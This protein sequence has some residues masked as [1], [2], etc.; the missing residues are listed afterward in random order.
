MKL[1]FNIYM[2]INIIMNIKTIIT[3]SLLFYFSNI[4]A[5][6]DL[7]TWTLIKKA[8]QTEIYADFKGLKKSGNMSTIWLLENYSQAKTDRFKRWY[9]TKA[10]YEVDC[11]GKMSKLI[12]VILHNGNMGN[13]TI[14]RARLATSDWLNM[15]DDI[16]SAVCNI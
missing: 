13:G 12:Q 3:I 6:N 7:S 9:S 10:E 5:Q 4:F 14:V 15:K 11:P 8:E 2:T 1:M 16:H